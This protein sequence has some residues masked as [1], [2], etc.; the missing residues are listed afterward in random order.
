MAAVKGD[1]RFDRTMDD[2]IDKMAIVAGHYSL[3][4]FLRHFKGYEKRGKTHQ[5][6]KWDEDGVP[7]IMSMA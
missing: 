5:N 1:G 7:F 2:H 3:K 4:M 6:P